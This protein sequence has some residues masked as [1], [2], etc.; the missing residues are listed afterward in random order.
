[1]G[2]YFIRILEFFYALSNFDAE[3]IV[4]DHYLLYYWDLLRREMVHWIKLDGPQTNNAFARVFNLIEKPQ[5]LSGNAAKDLLMYIFHL[6]VVEY[7]NAFK[8]KQLIP[9]FK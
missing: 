9:W 8:S 1:M 6:N 2:G 3:S 4:E 5:N 7:M